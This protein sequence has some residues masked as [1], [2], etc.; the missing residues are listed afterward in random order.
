MIVGVEEHIIFLAIHGTPKTT[1]RKQNL[2]ENMFYTRQLLLS[3]DCTHFLIKLVKI[4]ILFEFVRSCN[5]NHFDT[6]KFLK[7]HRGNVPKHL[8]LYPIS[9][10]K[11]LNL[12]KEA[13]REYM[14]DRLKSSGSRTMNF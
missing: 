4:F 14:Q 11:L 7:V 2:D 12:D 5:L 10:E 9:P 3:T 13:C 6:K 1:G 8:L